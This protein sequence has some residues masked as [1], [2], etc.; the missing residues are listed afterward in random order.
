MAGVPISFKFYVSDPFQPFLYRKEIKHIKLPI[1]LQ[2]IGSPDLQ[3]Y[4]K[5]FKP[6]FKLNQ[7]HDYKPPAHKLLYI[8]VCGT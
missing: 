3:A 7:I 4:L 8:V 6:L 5:K 1:Y 2:L